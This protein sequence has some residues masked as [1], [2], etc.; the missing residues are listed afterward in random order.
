MQGKDGTSHSGK[1][2]G[3]GHGTVARADTRNRIHDF[4]VDEKDMRQ[5]SYI[6]YLDIDKKYLE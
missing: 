1:G 4:Y 3:L 2:L 6:R 5:S